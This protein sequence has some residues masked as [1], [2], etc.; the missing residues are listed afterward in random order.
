MPTVSSYSDCNAVNA[1]QTTMNRNYNLL[2][3][4]HLVSVSGLG[5]TPSRPRQNSP[6]RPRPPLAL[7]HV[8]AVLRH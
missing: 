5:P 8:V 6:P 4:E 3:P 2:W 7:D 1:A